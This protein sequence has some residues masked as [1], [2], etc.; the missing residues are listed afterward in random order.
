METAQEA[1]LEPRKPKSGKGGTLLGK[2]PREGEVRS[3]QSHG[4][5]EN[6]G[7]SAKG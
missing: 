4:S 6:H 2:T 7:E 5:G 3:A 1:K